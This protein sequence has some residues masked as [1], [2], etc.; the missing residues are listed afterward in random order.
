MS[1][2]ALEAALRRVGSPRLERLASRRVAAQS[3]HHPALE[4]VGLALGIGPEQEMPHLMIEGLDPHPLALVDA[5]SF[6]VLGM[7]QVD[8][9]VFVGFAG[10]L[11][12]IDVLVPFNPRQSDVVVAAKGRDRAA[13]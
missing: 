7:D 5:A 11:A 8:A 10:G 2:R 6:P 13:K 1:L 4:S 9:A 3:E 12:L